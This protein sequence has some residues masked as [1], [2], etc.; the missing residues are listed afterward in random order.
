MKKI[1]QKRTA[2]PLKWI[3]SG[4]ITTAILQSS[5]VVSL[6]VISFV[7][8]NIISFTNSIWVIIGTNIGST[9]T[10]RIISLLGFKI[11]LQNLAL[12]IIGITWIIMFVFKTNRKIHYSA[13]AVFGFGLLLFGIDF[14]KNSFWF[15]ETWFNISQF[16]WLSPVFFIIAWFI[17]T[18]ISQ[19]SAIT[20]TITFTAIHSGVLPFKMGI[21]MIIWANIGTTS[22]ALIWAINWNRSQKQV[23]WVHF[24]YNLV[25]AIFIVIFINPILN[26]L[27]TKA[28]IPQDVVGLA[29][30]HTTFNILWAI[31]FFPF[32][33]QV[34]KLIKKIIPDKKE[35]LDL[36]IENVDVSEWEMAILAIKQDTKNLFYR[37]I[38]LYIEIFQ[39]TPQKILSKTTDI[40]FFTKDKNKITDNTINK[41]YME[42]KTIEE[43]LINYSLQF[44][45]EQI[46]Q[47][48]LSELTQINQAIVN[49]TQSLSMIKEIKPEIDILYETDKEFLQEQIIIFKNRI[50]E[51]YSEIVMIPEIQ[52]KTEIVKKLIEIK[53]NIKDQT[54]KYTK[55]MSSGNFKNSLLNIFKKS[56]DETET[57]AVITVNRYIHESSEIFI[58]W[59]SSWLLNSEENEK[60]VNENK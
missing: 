57:Y 60:I 48:S 53:K 4:T 20:N 51:I 29:V 12:P 41:S 9:I 7:G 54:N 40:K 52:N 38:K 49:F 3:L 8:L 14:I 43:E 16:V 35:I 10:A 46:N 42:I 39:I 27:F 31:L 28:K 59:V 58:S 32:I 18:G 23:A 5:S 45:P 11:E 1:L 30:F 44:E 37:I 25:T 50:I 36:A 55:N 24:F 13:V 21:F 2:T 22:T 17:I 6:I 56:P 34:S 26:L 47:D 33:N 15:L 19:S